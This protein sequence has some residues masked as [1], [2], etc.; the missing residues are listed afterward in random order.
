MEKGAGPDA[1][2][3]IGELSVHGV[4][5]P[6]VLDVTVNKVG[7]NTRNQVPTV[8]FEA[9]ATLKRADFGLGLYV[10]QVSNEIRVHIT[11]EA[12]EKNAYEQY[13][14]AHAAQE[15]AKKAKQ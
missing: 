2:K 7:V 4:V 8:G 12:A 1:L 10:P 11:A 3:V 14:K 6:V 13:L 9:Q 15:A 5:K